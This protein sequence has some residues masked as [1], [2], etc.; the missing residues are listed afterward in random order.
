M[1]SNF[2]TVRSATENEGVDLEKMFG[3]GYYSHAQDN[4]VAELELYNK[5]RKIIATSETYDDLSDVSSTFSVI[6]EFIRQNV[7]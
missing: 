6:S 7:K 5:H 3:E 2:R 4:R 1:P